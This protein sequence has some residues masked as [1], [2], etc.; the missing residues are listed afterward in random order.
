VAG[1]VLHGGAMAGKPC[2]SPEFSVFDILDTKT[3]N[4]K[5][6]EV[7]K[8]TTNSPRAFFGVGRGGLVETSGNRWRMA[9][10]WTSSASVR[11]Q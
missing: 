3:Q 7:R 8:L 1:G 6:G 4:K 9:V 5:Y 10:P 2:P 11:E